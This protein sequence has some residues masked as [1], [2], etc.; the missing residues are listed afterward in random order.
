MQYELNHLESYD[1]EALLNE[2][3]RVA[4]LAR[5][6]TLKSPTCG[7]VKIPRRQNNKSY[8]ILSKSAIFFFFHPLSFILHLREPFG[9]L[10]QPVTFP[11]ELQQMPMVEQA[12]KYGS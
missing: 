7:R 2:I 8:S 1:D 6:A 4:T 11:F 10:L 3:R 12:I 9:S 5:M